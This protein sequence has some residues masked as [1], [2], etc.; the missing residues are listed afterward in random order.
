MCS[1]HPDAATMAGL[2]RVGLNSTRKTSGVHHHAAGL[3]GPRWVQAEP[4]EEPLVGP[5]LVGVS[6]PFIV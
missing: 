2:P 5:L 6:G 1:S 3:W 4:S